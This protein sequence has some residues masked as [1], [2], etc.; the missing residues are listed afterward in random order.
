MGLTVIL[1]ICFAALYFEEFDGMKHLNIF[2]FG[3]AV[4]VSFVGVAMI[5]FGDRKNV[6]Q[7]EEL[8][9]TDDEDDDDNEQIRNGEQEEITQPGAVTND[10][11][12][13]MDVIET[14]K[15]L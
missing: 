8:N 10:N 6:E 1:T 3:I 11:A 4:F 13:E 12:S 9:Q 15:L 7:R 14:D 2:I 5:A